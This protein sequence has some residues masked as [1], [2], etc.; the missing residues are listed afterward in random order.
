MRESKKLAT[1]GKELEE[2]QN[3]RR[4]YLALKLFHASYMHVG[5]PAV[6]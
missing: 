5:D 2:E 4:A 6:A 1:K 3:V